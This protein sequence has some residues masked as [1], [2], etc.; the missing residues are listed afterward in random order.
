MVYNK[1]MDS[2]KILHK[3]EEQTRE[4]GDSLEALNIADKATAA[5]LQEGNIEG[6]S[7]VQSAKFLTFR[8][9]FDKTGDENY[10]ILAKYAAEA[11]AEMAKKSNNPKALIVPLFNLAKSYQDLEE[12]QKAVDTYKQ[13][14]ASL[15]ANPSNNS[16]ASAVMQDMIVHLSVC[17]YKNGDKSALERA[18]LALSKLTETTGATDYEKEVWVSGGYLKIADML[19]TDD[20][21]QAKI[22]LEKA[23]EIIESNP[24]LVLRKIQL[25]NLATKFK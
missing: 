2:A 14:I 6:A 23:A 20:L 11:A 10:L 8:H 15:T 4:K 21:E 17:E 16:N 5:Y 12:F 13:A 7:A 9:L 25:K 18:E 1:A 3:K 22:A 19:R 24:E